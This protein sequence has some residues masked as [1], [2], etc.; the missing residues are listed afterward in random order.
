[1]RFFIVLLILGLSGLKGADLKNL[2]KNYLFLSERIKAE[3]QIIDSL[4]K[5]LDNK[6]KV[7]DAQKKKKV[8]S[9]LAEALTISDEIS[10]RQIKQKNLLEHVPSIH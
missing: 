10:I 7:I 1:M 6:V 2:E 3:Q 4:N 8:E 5:L 9:L